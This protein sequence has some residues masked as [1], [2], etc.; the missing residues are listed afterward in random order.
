M[1]ACSMIWCVLLAIALPM[2]EVSSR[3]TDENPKRIA[4]SDL[5]HGGT[6][7]FY[8]IYQ[9]CKYNQDGDLQLDNPAEAH[10][11]PQKTTNPQ[12]KR[13]F[14]DVEIHHL[15]NDSTANLPT[16]PMTMNHDSGVIV[17]SSS[18]ST[19]L[20]VIGETGSGT[21]TGQLSKTQSDPEI[22]TLVNSILEGKVEDVPGQP[23]DPYP[24]NPVRLGCELQKVE[25]YCSSR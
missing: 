20:G 11:S 14:P 3:P 2:N 8:L 5:I 25:Y 7:D 15:E 10:N 4:I 1:V 18:S 17:G 9:H 19:S 13:K 6:A 21:G 16:T 22:I 23:F 24:G 12:L